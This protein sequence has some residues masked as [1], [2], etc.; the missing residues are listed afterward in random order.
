MN[1][2]VT[3]ILLLL[4]FFSMSGQE[5]D[6]GNGLET[7]L[8]FYA[9]V[10][11][12]ALEPSSRIRASKEFDLLFDKYLETEKAFSIE[13]DFH[14]FISILNAPDEKFKL[15][16]WL[17][18]GAD[19][20]Y[21][22]RGHII[23]TDG[24]HI[25]L[26]RDGSMSEDLAFNS[27]SDKDWYGCLYYDIM[28]TD[29]KNK[30]L[31]FGIDPNGI[32]DNQKIVD[33]ITVKEDGAEFGAELFE[34]KESKGTFMNRLILQY[35]SDAAV[36]LHY[37]KDLKMIVHPHLQSVMGF[38]PG[39]GPTRIPDGTY[40]GYYLKKGKWLYKEKL[41]DHVYE[42]APRPQPVF[43]DSDEEDKKK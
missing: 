36:K 21:D 27:S 38:Q 43:M 10:M 35:S 26:I 41:F 19:E 34:D 5:I 6:T 14:K 29:E 1:K 7:D 25:E 13:S 18:K 17:I 20:T 40:E 8:Q 42:E 30:Y 9:D 23:R 31:I 2:S 33:V 24:Q 16:T 39:Q 4:S 11:I 28:N 15:V 37:N 22:F 32:Y 3:S 12:N